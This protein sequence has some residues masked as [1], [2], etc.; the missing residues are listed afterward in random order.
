MTEVLILPEVSGDVADAANWYDLEGYVGLGDK[1]LTAFYSYIAIL[2]EHGEIHR[3]VYSDFRRILLRPFPYS[4]YYRYHG[5][6][7]IISLVIH[8][9]RNPERIQGLLRERRAS[10]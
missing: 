1:F 7:L 6:K 5:G 4:L 2:Q 3:T 10:P 9:A 8:A